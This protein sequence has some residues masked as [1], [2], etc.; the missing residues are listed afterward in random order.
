MDLYL[1][2]AEANRQE[3]TAA[4]FRCPAARP[5]QGC[6]YAVSQGGGEAQVAGRVA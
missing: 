4:T 3:R 6:L 1:Q 5:G 2:T